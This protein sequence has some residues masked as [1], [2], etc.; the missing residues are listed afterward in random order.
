M[1]MTLTRIGTNTKLILTGDLKQSDRYEDNGLKDVL[2]KIRL[3]QGDKTNIALI[4]FD[5]GDIQRSP[6]VS[7]VLHIYYN[8]TLND[9]KLPIPSVEQ[10]NKKKND[11]N[12]KN[13]TRYQKL[14]DKSE[15][16]SKKISK[17][18]NGNDDAAMIPL[19]Q[20]R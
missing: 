10:I 9:R 19:Y 12:S 20:M 1:L 6:I 5:D 2:E 7:K 14:D 3:Y 13:E 8:A 15:K 11:T 16:Q 4:E 17:R 18:R